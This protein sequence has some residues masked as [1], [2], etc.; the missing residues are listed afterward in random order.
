[1]GVLDDYLVNPDISLLDKTRIQ[2]Q[3]LVPVMRALRA[4]L[5]REKA[6]AIVS[7]AL[8]DW[9]SQVFSEIGDSIDGPPG[10]KFSKMDKA[11]AEAT[12]KEVTVDMYRRD[13]EAV[14]FDV[15]S[16][17]FADFFRSLDEPELGALLVCQTDID[18]AAVGGEDVDFSRSQTLM[19]GGSSCT[20]RYKF[21]PR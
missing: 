19:K 17:H 9:S 1:M 11:L 8:R 14:E 18:I 21:A 4:E 12:L 5:G 15:T 10:R 13:R 20:F 6:D 3:V 16:C 7:T 2:A